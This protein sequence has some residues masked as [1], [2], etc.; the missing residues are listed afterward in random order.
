ME[1]ISIESA[2]ASFHQWRAQRS[3]RR[4]LILGFCRK[5][6]RDQ[7]SDLFWTSLCCKIVELFENRVLSQK[8][9]QRLELNQRKQT[10]VIYAQ[11]QTASF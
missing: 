10:L 7:C 1:S 6:S 3:N 2:E 4:E 5:S 8:F 9:K 11:F